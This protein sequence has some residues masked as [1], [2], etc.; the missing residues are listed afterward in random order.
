MMSYIGILA[1]GSLIDD[2]GTE[3]GPLISDRILNVMTPFSVEFA[4][5]SSSR[6]GA[7]TLVPIEDGGAQVLGVILVLDPKVDVPRAED[8]VWRRETRNE[9]SDKHYSRPTSPGPNTVL[10]EKLRNLAQVEIVLFT[11]I[12]A[13]IRNR[14]PEYLADLAIC[15]A[16]REAGAKRMDGISYLISVKKQGIYTPLMPGYEANIIQKAK[17]QTLEEAYDKIRSGDA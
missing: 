6:D 8:Y 4:R 5:S 7:P 10:V 15:S 3:L 2:P 11:K 14:A 17:A 13:N 1:Y 12:G 9:C 16:R